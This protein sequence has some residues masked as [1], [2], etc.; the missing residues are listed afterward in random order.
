MSAESKCDSPTVIDRCY[1]KDAAT[2]DEVYSRKI[3]MF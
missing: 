2:A 1:R 3:C